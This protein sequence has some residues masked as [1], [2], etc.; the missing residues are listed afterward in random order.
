MTLL[1]LFILNN[2]DH[3]PWQTVKTQMKCTICEDKKT[4][5]TEI[6]NFFIEISTCVLLKYKLDDS[7]IIVSN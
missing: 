3:V 6:Q 1:T 4:S 5:G 2:G 7:I